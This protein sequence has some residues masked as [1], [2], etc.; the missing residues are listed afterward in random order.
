MPFCTVFQIPQAILDRAASYQMIEGLNGPSMM[1]QPRAAQMG[2]LSTHPTDGSTLGDQFSLGW[3]G[4]SGSVMHWVWYQPRWRHHLAARRFA[5]GCNSSLTYDT[6][7][8][9]AGNNISLQT[10]S[11]DGFQQVTETITG[12]TMPNHAPKATIL[13]PTEGAHAPQ[14]TAWD[15]RGRV[16]MWKMAARS[17]GAG[18]LPSMA[19]WGPAT[20]CGESP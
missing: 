5:Y 7:F 2:T 16:Q 3:T 12:L 14:T 8:L 15:L 18:P 13:S 20:A 19:P 17:R 1:I 11:S 4:G 6:D 10:I 9:K